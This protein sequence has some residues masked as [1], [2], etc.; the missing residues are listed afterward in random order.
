MSKYRGIYVLRPDLKE[1]EINN[2][3]KK[4]TK[5]AEKTN[6]I[7][8]MGIKKMVFEIRG[9]KEGYYIQLI[10]TGEDENCL[11]MERVARIDDNIFKFINIK[12]TDDEYE[13]IMEGAE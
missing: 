11:D 10:Y 13:D 1:K 5:C 3:I 12:L 4:L 2:S 6:L 8:K 9:Y 7:N